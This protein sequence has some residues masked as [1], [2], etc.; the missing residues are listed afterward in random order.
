[1]GGWLGFPRALALLLTL[2]FCLPA[3]GPAQAQALGR[4][5]SPILT[6]DRDRLFAETD[7]GQRVNRELEAAS[8]AMAAET[9]KIEAAL[10]EEER[11][12]TQQRET[13]EPEA[14]RELA[15]AFDE[16][17]QALR[18]EREAAEANLRRQIEDAQ[19]TF[20]DRI[21]P[22]LGT[23]VRERGAVLI[24]DRRAI[25]LSAADVDITDEAI[26][27]S[28]AVLGDGRD[29]DAPESPAEPDPVAPLDSI[30]APA[31]PTGD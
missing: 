27:R 20:F 31:T 8:S 9:R 23:I 5:I 30:P 15:R 21:G 28:D 2:V 22:I 12:L 13:L 3:A 18:Q 24:L 17:V 26:A 10:E 14:F 6:V 29:V 1:M 25:L 7:F 4:V 16:K 19:A 11:N